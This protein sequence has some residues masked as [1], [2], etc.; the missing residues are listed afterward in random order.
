ME[1]EAMNRKI[2]KHSRLFI[3]WLLTALMVLTG[4]VPGALN[5]SA[6]T[7]STAE[8]KLA[9]SVLLYIGSNLARVRNVLTPIDPGRNGT[10]PFIVNGRTLVPIRFLAESTGAVVSY[11]AATQTAVIHAGEK[12]IRIRA[13][14]ISMNVNGAFVTLEVAPFTQNGRMYAPLRAVSEALGKHLFYEG[15][16]IVVSDV[17]SFLDKAR[18]ATLIA[19]QS[20]SLGMVQVAHS[21]T[22]LM[23]KLTAWTNQGGYAVAD[24]GPMLSGT[25]G[26]AAPSVADSSKASSAESVTS[27]QGT[28]GATDAFSTTNIQ[29]EGVDEGDILKTDGN[30]LFQVNR[31]RVLI[32]Q[33]LPAASMR[34]L[35]TVQLGAEDFW[36]SEIY[37]KDGRLTIIGTS[38]AYGPGPVPVP[39]TGGIAPSAVSGSAGTAVAPSIRYMP[40]MP[41]AVMTRAITYDISNPE[42]PVRTGNFEVEGSLLASRRIGNYLYLVT[43]KSLYPGLITTDPATPVWRNGTGGYQS[44]VP[45]TVSW[46]PAFTEANYLVVSGLDLTNPTKAPGMYTLLGAGQT[47]YATTDSLVVAVQKYGGGDIILP[48]KTILPGTMKTAAGIMR[49]MTET[50]DLYRFTLQDCNASLVTRG[51][52]PGRLLNQFSLDWYKDTLRVATTTGWAS[53][54]GSPT[55]SN[56]V[57]TLDAMLNIVG[58]IPDIAPGEQIYSTR[59]LGDRG[60]LVTYRTTDPLFVL[61]LADPA[62]PAILGALKI[63]GYSNYLHPYDE[64]HIIGFGKNAV[65]LPSQWDTGTTTAY[66][67]GMKVALFDVGDV[68]N[69]VLMHEVLIGDRGTDS[70][71]LWNHR[72]LLFSKTRN[73]IAF[74]VNLFEVKNKAAGATDPN[75]STQYGEMTWQGLMAWR[76]TLEKGFEKMADISHLNPGDLSNSDRYVTRGAYIGDVLYTLSNREVRATNMIGWTEIGRLVLP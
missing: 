27:P 75:A 30:L 6:A 62:A 24:G 46:C 15:G 38:Q 3:V 59:F 10:A 19:S 64:T 48:A 7:A 36:P 11:E 33:A 74:P 8:V 42:I 49:P 21:A 41:Q 37:V 66:Y 60:Y 51:T 4:P 17:P 45:T 54:T 14:S 67:Q 5:G 9:D 16:L 1:G 25:T 72:A 57:F 13:G 53:Q 26:N 70:E 56:Q 35:A 52:I 69:P 22:E 39:M 76:L 32:I 61:D 34:L 58:M 40:P 23:E 63:P 68:K 65:E 50:T 18:D 31:N 71:L 20:R 44:I 29:V 12:T 55:S 2:R 28:S 47:V 73:L 43:N